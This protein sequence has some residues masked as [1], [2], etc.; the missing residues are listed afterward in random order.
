ML[1]GVQDRLRL[2]LGG[3]G[4]A[5]ARGDI[6]DQERVGSDE[7]LWLRK[8]RPFGWGRRWRRGRRE[9][10]G[11]MLDDLDVGDLKVAP[12]RTRRSA[13]GAATTSNDE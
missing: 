1:S 5:H 9:A 3:I 13:S 7:T 8:A 4:L 12:E 11:D 10:D 2:E 6:E